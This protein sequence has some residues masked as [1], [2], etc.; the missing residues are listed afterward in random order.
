MYCGHCAPCP[1][2]ISVADVNKY[3][4]LA[5]AQEKVPETV[6]EHYRLL[7]HHASECIRCGAC[8]ERCPFSVPIRERMKQAAEVFGI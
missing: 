1:K 3:L 8:E 5:L 4:N 2:K 7:A 6:R